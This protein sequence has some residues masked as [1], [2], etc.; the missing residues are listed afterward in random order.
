MTDKRK[1]FMHLVS[2]GKLKT[3]PYCYI[4]HSTENLQLHHIIPLS[5]GGENI[6]NNILTL[7]GECHGKVHNNEGLKLKRE[8][9]AE[10]KKGE[11]LIINRQ[12]NQQYEAKGFNEVAAIFNQFIQL[13]P[14]I[15]Q[16]SKKAKVVPF[17]DT[18][19]NKCSKIKREY[20]ERYNILEDGSVYLK[21]FMYKG[22]VD[23]IIKSTKRKDGV[24]S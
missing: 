1:E 10:K 12:T 2:I 5:H 18:I 19:K 13:N 6:E 14:N 7:C 16:Y 8:Q 24:N 23:L 15:Y 9:I 22:E 3:A 4:C 11:F 21:N 20:P 17:G